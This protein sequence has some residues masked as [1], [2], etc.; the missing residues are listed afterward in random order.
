[1]DDSDGMSEEV[2]VDG[3]SEIGGEVRDAGAEKK[4]S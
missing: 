3:V 2:S 1:M 4:M